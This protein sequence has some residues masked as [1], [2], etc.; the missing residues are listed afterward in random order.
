MPFKPLNPKLYH[1][2]QRNLPGGVK[3][4]SEGEAFV[5]RY[6]KDPVKTGLR[7]YINQRG[8]E[9]YGNCPFCNDTRG[10]L[11]INHRW[12]VRDDEGN[13]NLFLCYC[14][15]EN[16]TSNIDSQLRLKEMV[17]RVG[18]RRISMQVF[19]GRVL[20]EDEKYSPLPPG[21]ITYL[22]ELPANHHAVEY[23]QD[24]GFDIKELV[25]KFQVGY[26]Y[27]SIRSLAKDRIYIPFSMDE[28]L[29][30]WQM[31]YIGEVEGK[32]PPKYYSC[33]G[34]PAKR[35]LYNF[36]RARKYRTMI[37]VEGPIDVWSTGNQ[38]VG[39]IGKKLGQLKL[40]RLKEVN[41]DGTLVVMLDPVQPPKEK[42]KGMKHQIEDAYERAQ[43]LFKGGVVKVYLPQEFDP[44]SLDQDY[45]YDAI[46]DAAKEQGC[47]VQFGKRALRI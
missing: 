25:K 10:R 21:R 32:W 11:Y 7:L 42:A 6:R 45:L 41:A 37:L 16:C 8:E 47:K 38:A 18:R 1:C 9:Y 3:V 27:D 33:P 4:L 31:R 12:G 14:Y 46:R 44:G 36:D 26:C 15:N 24:R 13:D 35:M 20:K 23:L 22:D 2:L 28:K 17:Y 19:P 5:A 43:G 34:Q 29:L 39:L 30:G 40:D